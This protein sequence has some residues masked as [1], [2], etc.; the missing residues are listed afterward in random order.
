MSATSTQV[1]STPAHPPSSHQVTTHSPESARR[2]SVAAMPVTDTAAAAAISCHSV[3]LVWPAAPGSVLEYGVWHG[4]CPESGCPTE[5]NELKR[6]PTNALGETLLEVGGLE[7]GTEYAFIVRVRTAHGW[8]AHTPPISETTMTPTDFPLPLLAPEVIGFV[9]CQTVRLRLP[10]LRYCLTNT[11]TALQYREGA[12]GSWR[13]L[14]DRVLGGIVDIDHLPA[15]HASRTLPLPPPTH[16]PL[17]PMHTTLRCPRFATCPRFGQPPTAATPSFAAQLRSLRR[18]SSP[19][20]VRH[21]RVPAARLRG[22][23]RGRRH[24]RRR[25]AAAADGYAGGAVRSSPDLSLS[26]PLSS[27]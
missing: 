6:Y 1:Y 15:V 12:A 9:D 4:P 24:P 5:A 8:H 20:A 7:P 10:V 25:D 16:A 23:R 22:R 14:R 3:T 2:G 19:A 21:A 27:P 26:S 13:L 18:A 17:Q 11:H